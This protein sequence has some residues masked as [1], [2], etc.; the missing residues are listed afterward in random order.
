VTA[1]APPCPTPASWVRSAT[2]TASNSSRESQFGQSVA[3]SATGDV[4]AVGAPNRPAGTIRYA[5]GVYRYH[6]DGTRWSYLGPTYVRGAVMNEQDGW[7]VALSADA[8]RLFI[9][10]PGYRRI[11]AHPSL[12]GGAYVV[13]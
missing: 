10:A 11:G 6:Y 7:S 9:G 8:E 12:S 3:V 4:V 5:G 2:F 13:G 1:G